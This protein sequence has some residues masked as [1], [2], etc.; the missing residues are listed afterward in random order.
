M[1]GVP[2]IY[3]YLPMPAKLA[4]EQLDAQPDRTIKQL[5]DFLEQQFKKANQDL[6]EYT[7]FS[8]HYIAI[9]RFALEGKA[10]EGNILDSYTAKLPVWPEPATLHG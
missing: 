1:R 4:I 6:D 9:R 3:Q 2:E 7:R 10:K 5:D 8:C